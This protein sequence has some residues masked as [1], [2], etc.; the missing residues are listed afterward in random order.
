MQFLPL[1]LSCL[2]HVEAVELFQEKVRQIEHQYG[3]EKLTVECENFI[4]YASVKEER[5]SLIIG[6]PPYINLKTVNRAD[7]E[8]A[9][10][11]CEEAGLS[12]S[13]MQ[14]MWFAFVLRA[15]KNRQ[16]PTGAG[17][18]RFRFYRNRHLSQTAWYFVS[19]IQ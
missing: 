1:L 3:C 8:Q 2:E 9:K 17:I 4:Q 18:W 12:S 16:K 5:Y 11:L 14:N 7:I 15:C 19:A 10:K 6:N 13:A